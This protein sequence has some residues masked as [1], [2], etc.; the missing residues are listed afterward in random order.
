[1]EDKLGIV[2]VTYNN[3]NLIVKQVECLKK[4]CKDDFEVIIIDN[5]TKESVVE[6]IQYY[7]QTLKCKYYKTHAASKNG[8]SSHAFACNLS[9]LKLKDKYK[10]LFYLDHDNFLVKEF[11][12][13]NTLKDK[14]IAG[15]GRVGGKQIIFGQDV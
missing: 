8:S 2:I 9:Y 12:V 13:I 7:N 14:V 10:Y 3:A 6:A 4:F 1:M 11:S 15:L 5:S